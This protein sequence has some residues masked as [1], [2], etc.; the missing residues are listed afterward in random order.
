M[1][2]GLPVF[3]WLAQPDL[4]VQMEVRAQLDLRAQLVRAGLQLPSY[5]PVA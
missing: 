2:A 5:Q 1:E 3:Q 4:G